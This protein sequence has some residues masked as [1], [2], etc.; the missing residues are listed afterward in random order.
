MKLSY[1][2]LPFFIFFII[3]ASI[4]TES[5]AQPPPP[6]P[7]GHGLANDNPPGGG[8]P[9]GDGMFLLIGLAGLYGGKKAY[10]L[11]KGVKSES[12]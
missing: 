10:D 12:Q 7:A 8:A 9:I 6:P 4:N 11:R 1:K 5:I 3:T 2:I